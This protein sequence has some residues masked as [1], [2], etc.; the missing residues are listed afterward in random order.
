MADTAR[1][2]GK[3]TSS[4]RAVG[5][6]RKTGVRAGS[7]AAAKTRPQKSPRRPAIRPNRSS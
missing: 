2:G 6:A 4:S 7:T 3:K 5:K 1:R